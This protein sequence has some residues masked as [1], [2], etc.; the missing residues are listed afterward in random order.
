MLWLL[1]VLLLP[2]L[3]LLLVVAT[4]AGLL[5]FCWFCSDCLA[6]GVCCF[7]VCWCPFVRPLLIVFELEADGLLVSEPLAIDFDFV[8]SLSP[9]SLMLLVLLLLLLLLVSSPPILNVNLPFLFAGTWTVFCW[10][11]LGFSFDLSLSFDVFSL[12]FCCLVLSTA[13]SS[14][15]MV[16]PQET[17]LTTRTLCDVL[18]LLV[19][20]FCTCVFFG[21][22]GGEFC[23]HSYFIHSSQC[24]CHANIFTIIHIHASVSSLLF[25]VHISCDFFFYF[26]FFSIY[27]SIYIYSVLCVISWGLTIFL[28]RK[29]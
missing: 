24:S 13:T 11:F 16:G 29:L 15:L 7:V 26:A 8:A 14:S 19:L 1:L 25:Y 23:E 20:L 2:L 18:L 28:H 3:L 22:V 27:I 9:L 12:S 17:C 21:K 4:A 10:L 6:V 5:R